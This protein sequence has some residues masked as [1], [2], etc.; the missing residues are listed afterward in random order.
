MKKKDYYVDVSDE[1]H[2]IGLYAKKAWAE[3]K[4]KGRGYNPADIYAVERRG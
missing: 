1:T 3:K 4:A 2:Y